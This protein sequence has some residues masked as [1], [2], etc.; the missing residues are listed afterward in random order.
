MSAQK[1]ITFLGLTLASVVLVSIALFNFRL[2]SPQHSAA[3]PN[4]PYA[5]GKD[6]QFQPRK[7]LGTSG[8]ATVAAR[9]HWKPDATLGE[10]A[11]AWHDVGNRLSEQL[12]REIAGVYGEFR[13]HPLLLKSIFQ[14][15]AGNPVGAAAALDELRALVEEDEVL[16]GEW[17][18][19]V[20]FCQGVTGLRLGENENCVSCCTNGSCIL[21]L[22][23]A[24]IHR[25]PAGSR[26]AIRYFT[27][28]LTVFPDDLE[29]RWLLN[30]AHM[31]LGQ[32]PAGVDPRQLIR[33]D[34]FLASE[35]DIGKFEDVS[36]R[37]GLGGRLNWAGG[38]VMEDFDGDGYFDLVITS[39]DPE[40]PM[41]YYRNRVDGTFEERT[42]A[43]GLTKQLGG[44]YCVQADYDN[45]GR[46]DLFI[47]RGGWLTI[48]MRPSLLRNK[49]DGTFV[50]VTEAAGLAKPA[51]IGCAAW[52]DFDGDGRLDLFIGCE[53]G[54]NRLYRN[55]G[56]GTFEDV[57]ARAGVAGPGGV[58]KG[59]AWI[60]YDNDGRP[61]LFVVFCGGG[62]RLYHNC[63]NGAFEDVTVGMGIDG[64]ANGFSCWAFDYDNDGWMDLF[65]VN[66]DRTL[67]NVVSGLL[68]QPPVKPGRGAN[69]L[70]RNIGGKGF[71]DVTSEVGL[72]QSFAAMGSNY[73]DFDNDGF[74]DFYLGAGSPDLHMLVPN[75]MFR[76]VN[77]R[78][79]AEVTG[80]SGTGLIQK[81][82]GVACGDWNRDGAVDVFVETGG[83]VPGDRFH[84]HLF[85]NPGQRGRWLSL[86]LEGTRSNHSAIGARI[87][88][89][90]DEPKPRQIFRTV[91]T[92]SSFG[93]NPLEVHVGLGEADQAA[94]I[95]VYWP[96]SGVTQVFH[97]VKAGRHYWATEGSSELRVR[98]LPPIPAATR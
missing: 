40:Q 1:R 42:E 16:S 76:N 34:R 98:N 2:G 37:V 63:G 18:Y 60:D 3:E 57:A 28:Y 86:K 41:A 11:A 96:T 77:G 90:I 52:A 50:D 94:V 30:L 21:P 33:L 17:L 6:T 13:V 87:R 64:P 71:R 15:Y 92:G 81:G 70:Y 82:H 79:F 20:I 22:S 58:C 39:N 67:G 38:A 36:T 55:R 95:E 14:N 25:S 24:A 65:V 29:V 12:D 62:C 72:D 32:H 26:Q 89:V 59:C 44:L 35:S 5:S 43:A 91:S 84:N 47:A 74:L 31:T 4:Q 66:Y 7:S 10:I 61:D 54:P 48:P 49:G 69:R 73:G 56:D 46:P 80:S 93:A 88:I 51:N 19:T 97:D 27:E 68:G 85:Q 23:T 9:V 75:R 53:S 78:R 8:Y 83:T 45:D